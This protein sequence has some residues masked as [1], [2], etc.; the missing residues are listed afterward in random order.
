MQE[1]PCNPEPDGQLVDIGDTRLW[2]AQRGAGQP[3]ILLHGGPGDDHHEFADYLDPLGD[4]Y[5]LVLVDQRSQGRSAHAPE[6]TWT[7]EQMAHDVSALAQA[8]HLGRYAVLGHSYGAFVALQH[9]VDEP[10]AAAAT[11]VSGGVPSARYLAQVDATLQ[12]FEPVEL[13]EQV[14]ASWARE[15]DVQTRED[16]AQLM[17]AQMPFHFANPRDPRIAEYET[18]TA[19]TCFA[20]DVLRHFARQEYGGIEVEDRLRRVTQPVLVLA[21]R[22]DRVCPVA[23]AEAMA[24][25]VPHAELM[26]FEA[27]GHMTFV[28]E[29]AAYLAAVRDF[30]DRHFAGAG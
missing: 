4:R 30:L 28:E 6:E 12:A 18:R 19:G 26:L 2:V 14:A 24:R 5:R 29:T 1:I 25:G 23:A 11:I 8:M 9:A 21:G 20:P 13:R 27:S 7:L 22:H 16:F 15:R 10:G 3:L 17:H